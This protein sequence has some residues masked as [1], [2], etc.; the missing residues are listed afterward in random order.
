MSEY[1]QALAEL[2]A[3]PR[4]LDERIARSKREVAAEREKREGEIEAVAREHGEVVSRLEAVLARARGEGVDLSE[5]REAGEE[6]HGDGSADPIAYARQLV[7]RLEEA[8]N[9]F[10][11][12]R[13][14]LAAEEA[15][16]SKEERERAAEERRRHEREQ[17]R[18][19]EQWEQ[20]RQGA[21]GLAVGLVVALIVGLAV[22]LAGSPA[23]LVVPVLAAAAGFGLATAVTSTLPALAVR[24]ATGSEP[25]LPTAPPREARLGAGG[26]AAAALAGSG[27]GAALTAL[28]NGSAGAAL[29]ALAL[30]AVGL[31]GIAAV[32]WVLPRAK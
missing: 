2:A 14:A 9:H 32:W 30:A 13:D 11:Y 12:T 28:A 10:R 4:R 5:G 15:K 21:I 16:L 23:V 1:T 22:G 31:V 19:A 26:Y 17:L 29:G 18:R 8:L 6:R 3:L 7:T 27:L 20:A 25:Q 24:R